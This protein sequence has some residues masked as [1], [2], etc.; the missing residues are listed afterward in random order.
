[1]LS[2][3]RPRSLLLSLAILLAAFCALPAQAQAGAATVPAVSG[4]PS[5]F[6]DLNPNR[7]TDAMAAKMARERNVIRQKA[8]VDETN[9]LL[10]LAKQLKDAVDKT[11]KNQLSLDV[12][13]KAEQ[14]EKLAK[15]V[16]TK[17]RDGTAEPTS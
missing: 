17:M 10:D 11:D 4:P 16:K 1:M 7:D 8:I 5:P 15:D 6:G 13:R 9:Q 3:L 14:I 2:S 12:V